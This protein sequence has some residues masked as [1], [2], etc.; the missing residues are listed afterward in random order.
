MIAQVKAPH[1]DWEALSALVCLTA[2]MC[3]VLLVGLLRARFVRRAL[4]PLLTLVALAATAAA[5]VWQ[6]DIDAD[7]VSASLSIDNLTLTL[8]LVF[9][10]AAAATVLLSWRSQAAAE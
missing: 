6:W 3:V 10:V 2:G 8:T 5:C 9:V 4:V 1:I 7:I